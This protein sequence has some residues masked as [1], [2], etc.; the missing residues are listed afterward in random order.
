MQHGVSVDDRERRARFDAR[1]SADYPVVLRFIERR[2]DDDQAAQ[3]IAADVF[4]LLWKKDADTTPLGRGWLCKTA[5][6]LIGNHYRRT[7]RRQAAE[8][9]TQILAV[10]EGRALPV[11]DILIVREA[12]ATLSPRARDIVALHY[13]D[14]LSAPEIAEFLGMTASAVWTTLSRARDTLRV[15]LTPDDVA[16][17]GMTHA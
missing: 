9:S 16:R 2:I 8:A 17:G 13:W 7:K 1:F 6:H 10:A 5:S 11:S 12:L 4:L 14:G 15:H 3:D